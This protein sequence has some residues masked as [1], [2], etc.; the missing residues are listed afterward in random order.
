MERNGWP[1]VASKMAPYPDEQKTWFRRRIK[2]AFDNNEKPNNLP[3]LN[4][5]EDK[6]RAN[7]GEKG[8]IS[9]CAR[10]RRGLKEARA[11]DQH[12]ERAMRGGSGE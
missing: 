6:F 10:Y 3:V 1:P 7:R 9:F 4:E 11:A 8:L 5:F 2:E 12:M